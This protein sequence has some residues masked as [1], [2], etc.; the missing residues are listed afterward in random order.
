MNRLRFL[1]V[2]M[3]FTLS[4]IA[5]AD[6]SGK[7]RIEKMKDNVYRFTAGNY[8]SVFMVTERGIFLTDPINGEAATWLKGEL[9][10]RFDIPVR[11]MAYSHNHVDHVMGGGILD[12]PEVTLVAHQ[13][14]A[15]DLEWTRVPTAMPELTF[16]DQLQINLGDSYVVLRYHGPNNGRGSV[17]MRFMPAG[18]LHVVDWIVVGR[19]P[20][21][22]LPGYDIH[23]MIRSTRE[24]LDGPPFDLFVG[25]HADSG[26]REDVERYL[27]YLEALYGAVRDGMLEGKDLQTLQAEIRL[28]E[29]RDLKMYEAWLPLNIEGVYN[30]LNDMSYFN[31]RKDL[32]LDS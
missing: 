5:G 2:L 10:R 32:P 30:T 1:C 3:V 7:Y 16:R 15:E 19:M 31:M 12:G 22:T 17:S 14:A 28:Q 29:Y 27:G 8:R 18:V 25:G 21:K 23:G 9:D 26:N 13:Y 24:V 4:S 11:Y 6:E 20:Y